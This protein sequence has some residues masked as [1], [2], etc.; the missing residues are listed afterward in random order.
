MAVP[1]RFLRMYRILNV[2]GVSDDVAV[3]AIVTL[4]V[5]AVAAQDV[6]SVPVDNAV[7]V[8]CS[9]IVLV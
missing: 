4:L 8:S 2:V 7:T 3:T 9:V 6:V 1:P 5:P